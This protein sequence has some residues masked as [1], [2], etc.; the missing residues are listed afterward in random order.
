MSFFHKIITRHFIIAFMLCSTILIAQKNT[1]SEYQVKAAFI[2][3]FTQFVE[4]PEGTFPSTSVPFVIGVLG[5]NPFGTYL[6]EIITGEKVKGCPITVEYYENTEAIKSC[7]ILYIS[8]S[9]NLK[10]SDIINKLADRSILTVS[11]ISDFLEYGGMIRFYTKNDKIEIHI[12][13]DAVN[14]AKLNI[15]SKL[16]RLSTISKAKKKETNAILVN[17]INNK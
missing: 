6:E 3:N 9:I 12:N 10:P 17:G 11:D 8:K 4:W 13:L 2:F 7:H 14:T 1:V 15:S 16:L 5:E